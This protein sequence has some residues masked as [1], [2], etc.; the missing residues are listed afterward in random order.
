MA[1]IIAN[2]AGQVMAVVFA[3]IGTVIVTCVKHIGL[4]QIGTVIAGAL[5][6]TMDKIVTL[7]IEGA[8]VVQDRFAILVK[9]LIP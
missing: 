8:R 9:Q 1:K 5:H 7:V 6:I 4:G 2:H 3:E